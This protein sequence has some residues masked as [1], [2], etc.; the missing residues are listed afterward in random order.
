MKRV[1]VGNDVVDLT[2]DRT[3]G[4]GGDERFIGR[5]FDVEEQSGIR[6]AGS[7]DLEL[8]SR[9]A[10]KEAGFKAISK[11]LGAPPP[12]VHRAFKVHWSASFD[13]SQGVVRE[14]T[15][16]YGELVA[17]ITVELR[18]GAVHAVAISAAASRRGIRVEPRV[19][20]IDEPGSRWSHGLD[21]LKRS[22]TPQELDAVYSRESAAVRIGARADLA[23]RLEVKEDRL[24]IVCAPGATSQRPPRVLLDGRE[25]PA[26]VSLSHD[27]PW[28]AWAIWVDPH[29]GEPT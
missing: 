12:F 20:T 9:W 22:F 15:V 3:E 19:V 1:F 2:N 17:Q 25:A 21:E 10:A 8:W 26:D 27:G 5:V 16:R 23:T 18:P 14:G 6:G 24:E 28:L 7:S 29:Y 11:A 4:R 13:R